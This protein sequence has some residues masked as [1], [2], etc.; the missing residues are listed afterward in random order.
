MEM[1][2]SQTSIHLKSYAAETKDEYVDLTEGQ[3]DID[4]QNQ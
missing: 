4:R 3:G 1:I 2:N